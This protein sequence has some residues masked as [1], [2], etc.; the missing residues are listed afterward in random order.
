M[1]SALGRWMVERLGNW[2]NEFQEANIFIPFK[3]ISRSDGSE[4]EE[5]TYTLAI[6]EKG[7]LFLSGGDYSP[8]MEVMVCI[9]GPSKSISN[10]SEVMFCCPGEI[11][12]TGEFS[13]P[14]KERKKYKAVSISFKGKFS[15]NIKDHLQ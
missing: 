1:N 12:S 3:V 8:G 14:T 13:Y 9:A 15:L 11:I 4:H 10:G 2:G 6:S 7:M 5:Q